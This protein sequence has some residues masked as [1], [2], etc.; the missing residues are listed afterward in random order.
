MGL[1]LAFSPGVSWAAEVVFSES[2]DGDAPGALELKAGHWHR[3]AGGLRTVDGHLS[4]RRFVVRDLELQDWRLSFRVKRLFVPGRDQHFGVIFGYDDGT[5]LRIYCRGRTIHCWDKAGGKTFRHE[6]LGSD[7]NPPLPSGDDTPWTH[8]A[9]SAKRAYVQVDVGGRSVGTVRREPATLKMAEFYAY[10]L[11]CAFDDILIERLSSTAEASSSVPSIPA[12]AVHLNFDGTLTA[13]TDGVAPTL[14]PLSATGLSFVDGVSGQAVR[15]TKEAGVRPLLHYPAGDAFAGAGGTVMFWFRPEW[16]GPI[17]DPKRFPWYGLF[18]ALDENG[19]TALRI[20]QWNWLRADLPRATGMKGFSLYNRCRG[21]WLKGDW[22]HVALVW[23]EDGWCK[24]YADGVP[25]ERGLTGKRY[26]PKR[27]EPAM[28]SIRSFSIGSTPG[29]GSPL[30]TADGAF[31]DVR[32]YRTPLPAAAVTAEI[33]KAFPVD[34]IVERRFVKADQPASFPVCLHPGGRMV[35]PAVGAPVAIPVAVTVRCRLVSDD[36][37]ESLVD[38]SF[39]EDVVDEIV[40]P[41]GLPALSPGDYRLI[42]TVRSGQASIQR[43]FPIVAYQLGLGQRPS[44]DDLSPGAPAVVINCGAEDAEVLATTETMVRSVQGTPYREAGSDKAD[45]FAFEIE[46]PEALR[47]G[48]PVLLEIVWPDDKSR[49]IGLY[50]YP[51]AKK[52]QHRDR[53]EGGIQSGEEYPISGAMQ[54]VRYLFYPDVPRYLFEARTIIAGMPAAVA[55]VTVRPLNAP[56]PRLDIAYPDGVA[57]RQLGHMDEDQS[58][59]ILFRRDG[60]SAQAV[61]YLETLCD[62]F[63][64]TGQEMIAYP[65]LRYHGAY[66]PTIG[67]YPGRGLRPEGWIDLF[68]Q[69]LEARGKALIATIN[70]FTLPQFFLLPDRVDAFIEEEL[71]LRD[72]EGDL[73]RG[74]NGYVCNPIHPTA[75]AAL[76][77]HIGEL[78]RRYGDRD[79][80]AGLDLWIGP[81]WTFGGLARGYSDATVERFAAE[82]GTVVPGGEGRERFRLRHAFLTGPALEPW[83][84]WRAR[85]TTALIA[86]IDRMVTT[87]RPGL[88]LYLSIP[89]RPLADRADTSALAAHAFRELSIDLDAL[90]K[91]RSV[92]L[93]PQRG[94]TT[95]RHKKHWDRSET[96]H[97]EILYERAN[98]VVFQ[99]PGR[100]TSTHYLRYFESFN[101][102]LKPE[103]YNSYFQN[104]DVKAHGRFFLKEFAFCLATMDTTRMLIGAQP[105]GTAGRD[106]VTREFARAYCALPA[107]GFADVKGPTDPVTV[108]SLDTGNA[109]YVYAVNTIG[110]PV[111]ASLEL[112]RDAKGVD[113]SCGDE[114]RTQAKKLTV[115][116]KP[117]QLRSFTF[118]AKQLAVDSYSVSVPEDTRAWYRTRIDEAAAAVRAVAATGADVAA[119]ENHVSALRSAFAEGRY[120]ETH[121]LLF[122]KCMR[123]L[124]MIGAAAAKGYL[125][126]QT[127]MVAASTYAVNCGM[128]EYTFYRAASGTLFFPDQP[129]EAGDYGHVGSY[130]NVIRP[131]KGIVGTAD[132]TL[133]VTEAYDIDGY[134]FTVAPGTYTVR[135]HLKHGWK[136]AA[137]PGV[138][139][140]N[141]DLEGK[142]VLDKADIFLLCNKEFDRAIVQE[143]SGV[144][145][146]DGALDVDFGYPTG[147]ERTARLCNAIEIIPED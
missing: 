38:T 146:T 17:T 40:L 24:L 69:V 91:L 116:L 126:E 47:Q 95:Y 111:C 92:V 81:T 102:S 133:Y 29:S 49:S 104:A 84:A 15:V 77:Q 75:R 48:P 109:L 137:R 68:L 123:E 119:L 21:S 19:K 58:F 26:L 6:Q 76:L 100:A 55:S 51:E 1:T 143:F 35:I 66:Y 110:S 127:R 89:L 18:S 33:H 122:A 97:D 98:S 96:R 25:Y 86:E 147:G 118:A 13:R 65:L 70:L 52:R 8:F 11:D 53:L 2:F 101:N 63:D 103:V 36:D 82:T 22:H 78:L 115:D 94:P 28:D 37:G 145:V 27:G 31:D 59:E 141:V 134:R 10:H 39:R 60:G 114:V 42:C 120:A 45:R 30:K 73:V 50:M 46:I 99:A 4:M 112:S 107:A 41:V 20:W 3:D 117:F 106:E 32:V 125:A 34:I 93:V 121:R 14:E 129:F 124:T 7:L 67:S 54:T 83:L 144:L 132:A 80:F 140:I 136:P 44:P 5:S 139:V 85:Q 108:R 43:S 131:T 128:G 105:L 74:R 9:I 62:Y 88:P 16:D 72:G 142:R 138:F 130:K 90:R 113:L 23:N 135:L 71:F 79:A 64:Y 61:R 57:H 56:L 87:L 12:L